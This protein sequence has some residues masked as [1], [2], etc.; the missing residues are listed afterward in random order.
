MGMT[1]LPIV[2]R[3]LRGR[4][5]WKG[6]YRLRVIAAALSILVVMGML[7]VNQAS[8]A[9]AQVGAALFKTLAWPAFFHC[10]LAGAWTTADCLSKEKREGTLGL[11]FLT[12]L[13]GYDVV[14]GKF[15][16]R[17]LNPL[18]GLIAIFP[19]LGV[20]LLLGG[21]TAGEFWRL[22]LVL[23]VTMGL[24]LS[25]G[26]WVSALVREERRAWG[27]TVVL[28]TVL[29]AG[30]P[31]LRWGPSVTTSWSAFGPWTGLVGSLDGPYRTSPGAYWQAIGSMQ[32]TG[33]SISM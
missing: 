28:M 31:L 9:S 24:S 10:W 16:A 3:E 27:M 25:V 18:Y 8:P 2:D 13:K 15:V 32:A 26:M 23:L 19:A 21:V 1:F 6:T 22:V 11:L 12:D 30:P 20:P 14:F 7:L 33:S 17:A 4:A 5:R 29:L